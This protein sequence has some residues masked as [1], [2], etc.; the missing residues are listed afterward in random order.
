MAALPLPIEARSIR[1]LGYLP[2][3]GKGVQKTEWDRYTH[4]CS[5]ALVHWG[6]CPSRL[7]PLSF[8]EYGPPDRGDIT[9]PVAPQS[10]Y[11]YAALRHCNRNEYRGLWRNKSNCPIMYR[12][13]KQIKKTSTCSTRAVTLVLRQKLNLYGEF[14]TPG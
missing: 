12:N 2:T 8:R 4:L 3:S 1:G 6:S 11:L 7:A 13:N 10:D 9:T 14:G 5:C